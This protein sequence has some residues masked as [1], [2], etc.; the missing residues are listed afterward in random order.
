MI[1][2]HTFG[3]MFGLPDPSP[4]V[5]KAYVLLKMSGVP[6]RT[7]ATGLRGAPKGKLPF[8]EDDGVS[9]A[10]S[11]FI[12]LHLEQKHHIDF[13]QHLTPV[14]RGIAWSVEKMLE[15]H[16]YWILLQRRW[17]DD[18]NFFKGPIRFFDAVPAVIRPLVVKM[19]R[20]SVRKSLYAQGIGRHSSD[21]ITQLGERSVDALAQVMADKPYLLGDRPCGADATAFSFASGLLCPLFEGPVRTHAQQY[22]NLVSYCARLRAEFYPD[23]SASPGVSTTSLS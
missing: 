7:Q 11:T 1:I 9:V 6:F 22:E 10:D 4:F 13:D 17:M 14:Q 5:T 19:V 12:R 3:P 23:S 8:I 16:L 20:R 21:E 15:D 18:A 2:L